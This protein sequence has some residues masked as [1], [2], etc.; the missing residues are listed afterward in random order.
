MGRILSFQT[1]TVGVFDQ[2][3]DIEP[4]YH[5][6]SRQR[7]CSGCNLTILDAFP[8]LVFIIVR[9]LLLFQMFS[10]LQMSSR[11]FQVF[12]EF[13][14]LNQNLYYC[15]GKAVPIVCFF[16]FFFIIVKKLRR[17]AFEFRHVAASV[18]ARGHVAAMCFEFPLYIPCFRPW[19]R[20]FFLPS[21]I[22][23]CTGVAPQDTTVFCDDP[24]K[25]R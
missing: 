14:Q 24:Q 25:L 1:Q 21:F 15:Y 3:Q 19:R 11:C 12:S 10:D 5:Y 8:G 4:P 20:H 17:P 22:I 6:T 9:F 16:C 13:R 7:S 18:D 23:L 2:V